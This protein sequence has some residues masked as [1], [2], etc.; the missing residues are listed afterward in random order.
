MSNSRVNILDHSLAKI[1]NGLHVGNAFVFDDQQQG[2]VRGGQAALMGGQQGLRVISLFG[3]RPFLLPGISIPNI[4]P[5]RP[6]VAVFPRA[7]AIS[8]ARL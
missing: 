2:T 5:H 3:A 1:S 6:L 7:I 8:P 4:S